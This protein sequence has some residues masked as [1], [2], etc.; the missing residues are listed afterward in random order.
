M[1][2]AKQ[3]ILLQLVSLKI[4]KMTIITVT[5]VKSLDILRRIA[6]NVGNGSKQKISLIKGYIYVCF[7]SNLIEVPFNTWWLDSGATTHI[8][9]TVQRFLSI[10]TINPN[11]NFVLTGN[12]GKAPIE[13]IGTYRLFLDTNKT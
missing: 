1:D 13:A 9:N 10:Q 7:E 5:S 2:H 4:R 6:Q 8:S 11:K 3:V 12:R